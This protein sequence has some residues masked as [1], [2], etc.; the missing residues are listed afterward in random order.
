MNPKC[1]KAFT[2]LRDLETMLGSQLSR[3]HDAARKADSPFVRALVD[4]HSLLSRGLDVV[5]PRLRGLRP[6][7]E[8]SPS[9]GG[10]YPAWSACGRRA[11]VPEPLPGESEFFLDYAL[12]LRRL[13][14]EKKIVPRFAPRALRVQPPLRQRQ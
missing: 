4:I 12:E 11:Y 3:L 1:T 8:A 6:A 5:E 9:A 2:A 14:R 7:A 13:E 10:E